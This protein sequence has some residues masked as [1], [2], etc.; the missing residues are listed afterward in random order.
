MKLKP[1]F[2]RLDAIPVTLYVPHK[3]DRT[4][5][6]YIPI[7]GADA[8]MRVEIAHP[9]R[10]KSLKARDAFSDAIAKFYGEHARDVEE[11]LRG[12]A[13]MRTHHRAEY[14]KLLVD[15]LMATIEGW[16]NPQGVDE[17][18][19]VLPLDTPYDANAMRD[20]LESDYDIAMQIYRQHGP[21]NLGNFIALT[22]AD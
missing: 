4:G 10:E 18:D 12:E 22:S 17:N 11:K 16:Q 19:N 8:P 7:G 13:H 6:L 20:F 21:I 14:L 5:K 2:E 15:Y 9:E 3:V 1:G